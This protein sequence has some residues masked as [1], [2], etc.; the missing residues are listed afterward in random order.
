MTNTFEFAFGQIGVAASRRK[1]DYEMGIKPRDYKEGGWI[2]R[3]YPPSAGVKLDLGKT[4]LSPPDFYT[5]CSKAVLLLWFL[6]VTCSWC[7][8]LCFGSAIMLVTYFVNFR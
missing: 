1:R 5:D 6:I 8:Y 4:G 2:W 7:P 3:W